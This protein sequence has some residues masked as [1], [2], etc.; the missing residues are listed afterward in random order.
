MDGGAAGRLIRHV[1]RADD[2]LA[3][4]D[5]AE[6]PRI[7][8]GDADGTAPLF[9]Q[10]GIVQ[11]QEAVRRTLR[12]QGGHALLIEGLGL[13]GRIGQQMLSAF[14]RGARHRCGDGVAVL[15]LQVREQTRE[16]A[17]HACPAG[18]AAEERCE[19]LQVGSAFWQR[20]WTGF[21]YTVSFHKEAYDVNVYKGEYG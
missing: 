21:R 17:L 11:P 5:L 14:G 20:V 3:I 13:P 15:P 2:D 16:V 19:G 12:H 10:A 18:R 6:G 1:V 9:G 7:L 4:G 8:A